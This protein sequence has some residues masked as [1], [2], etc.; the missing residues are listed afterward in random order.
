MF[1]LNYPEDLNFLLKPTMTEMKPENT[2]SNIF[3]L[4]TYQEW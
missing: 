2:N 4:T 1:F 3:L